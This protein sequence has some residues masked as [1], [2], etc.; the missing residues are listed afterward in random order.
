M[1]WRMILMDRNEP[2]QLLFFAL[3][4]HALLLSCTA[5]ALIG[6]VLY[7]NQ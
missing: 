4:E 1:H 6:Q 2:G 3:V 5:E 7:F